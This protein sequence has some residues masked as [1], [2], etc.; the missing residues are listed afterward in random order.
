MATQI[1]MAAMWVVFSL[2][3]LKLDCPY[4]TECLAGVVAQLKCD[5]IKHYHYLVIKQDHKRRTIVSLVTYL[6]TELQN[7]K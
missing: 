1:K 3:S 4:F 6:A 2:I 7:K 5:K